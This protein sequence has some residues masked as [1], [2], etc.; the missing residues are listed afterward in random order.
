MVDPIV[1]L[2]LI[3]YT[4][5][6]R[7]L[8]DF[9]LSLTSSF[10]P[11]FIT[12]VELHNATTYQEYDALHT[13]MQ[14]LNFFRTIIGSDNQTYHLPMAEYHSSGQL[15]ANDVLKLAA[16]AVASIAK[17]ALILVTEANATA[18]ILQP[19]ASARFASK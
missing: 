8:A 9:V 11:Q 4:N 14:R 5:G 19:T 3:T 10:M 1:H 17:T 15:S 18:F 16:Q 6:T 12:R 13:A 2:N 7:A